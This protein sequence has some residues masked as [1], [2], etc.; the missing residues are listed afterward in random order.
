L[1]TLRIPL[2]FFHPPDEELLISHLEVGSPNLIEFIGQAQPLIDSLWWL[3]S[4][5]GAT[6]KSINIVKGF[7]EVREKRATALKLERE[8]ALARE[9]DRLAA[10]S[11]A[12]LVHQ[13][14]LLTRTN[15]HAASFTEEQLRHKEAY[16]RHAQSL[17]SELVPAFAREPKIVIFESD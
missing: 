2:A 13:P 12:G 1:N 16:L 7:Y 9:Q 14:D 6:L 15:Q 11:A 17:A 3:A 10:K 5:G 8:L 4:I